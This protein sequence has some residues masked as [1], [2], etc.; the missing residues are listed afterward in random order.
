MEGKLGRQQLMKDEL[1]DERKKNAVL[2]SRVE[3]LIKE[4]EEV[5][6]K[7]PFENQIELGLH[8]HEREE[9]VAENELF[10][11]QSELEVDF[12]IDN[13]CKEEYAAT[14]GWSEEWKKDH[15]TNEEIKDMNECKYQKEPIRKM[16]R[17]S[18][19]VATSLDFLM[20]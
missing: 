18:K 15:L 10:V 5:A 12:H 8:L 11:N 14:E 17:N 13:E 16:K 6:K 2:E 4:L 7:K 1:T 19:M 9:E 20:D 3:E